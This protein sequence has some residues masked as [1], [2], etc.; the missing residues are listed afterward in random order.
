MEEPLS[1][2]YPNFR[3]DIRSRT[4]YSAPAHL[5]EWI[6][7][8]GGKSLVVWLPLFDVGYLDVSPECKSGEVEIDAYWGLR[9]K[10]PDKYNWESITVD[11]GHALLFRSDLMHRSSV[12]WNANGVRMTLQFRY[13]DLV[14]TPRPYERPVSQKI[15]EKIIEKQK[16]LK[17]F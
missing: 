15:T 10:N 7:F 14:I 13:E 2:T 5:D 9:L 1:W 8:R 17:F 6:S 12:K 16:N 11:R 4:T 3:L